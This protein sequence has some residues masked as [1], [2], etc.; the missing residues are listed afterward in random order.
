MDKKSYILEIAFSFMTRLKKKLWTMSMLVNTFGEHCLSLFS[1]WA[2]NVATYMTWTSQYFPIYTLVTP[3]NLKR[4]LNLIL[5][6]AKTERCWVHS[7]VRAKIFQFCCLISFFA[8]P[9]QKLTNV[10]NSVIHNILRSTSVKVLYLL[11]CCFGT[12]ASRNV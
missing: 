4:K 2:N 9:L 7:S 3:T 8:F 12:C 6:M 1:T 5:C 11:I 10:D